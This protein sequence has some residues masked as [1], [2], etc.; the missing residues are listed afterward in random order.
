MLII[1]TYVHA[2]RVT[3]IKLSG[4]SSGSI[5]IN[6]KCN[7]QAHH[8]PHCLIRGTPDIELRGGTKWLS[9]YSIICN[10]LK[11]VHVPHTS[12]HS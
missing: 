11:A 5:M 10:Y 2:R 12:M 3:Q 7:Q 6:A 8:D 4:D 1:F 9:K